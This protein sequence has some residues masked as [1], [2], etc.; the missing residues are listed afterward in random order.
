MRRLAGVWLAIIFEE[1]GGVIAN[2]GRKK[3]CRCS[4]CYN[5]EGSQRDCS[6]DGTRWDGDNRC[7]ESGMKHHLEDCLR[8]YASSGAY[9]FH[10]PGHKRVLKNL[11]AEG[12]ELYSYDI[13]E[14]DGFDNLHDPQEILAE[15][16]ALAARLYGVRKTF[17]LVGGSTLGILTAISSAVPL[18]G[19][20]L[21]ERGCH[22]SVYHA[23]H[24]RQLHI[25]YI[26]DPW[27]P[28]ADSGEKCRKP[29]KNP[30]VSVS[31]TGDTA[32]KP[33]EAGNGE[34]NGEN[35]RTYDAI[36]LTSPTYEGAV[37]PVRAWAAFARQ[38][39]AILIIDEAHGAHL[40]FHADFPSSATANGADLVVQSLH[41]TLPALTQTALLHNVSGRVEDRKIQAFLDIYETS[42]PSYLLLASV[43]A[44]LHM[45]EKARYGGERHENSQAGTE[46]GGK[47]AEGSAENG[48]AEHIMENYVRRLRGLRARLSSLKNFGLFGGVKAKA[49][50]GE[51]A[52][53]PAGTPLDPGKIVLLSRGGMDGPA[54]YQTLRE[55]YRLQPEMCGP[56]YVLCM[57]TVADTGEGFE[58]LASAME[59]LDREGME[60]KKIFAA[61][62]AL[63]G[64]EGEVQEGKME[65][66]LFGRP[67]PPVA[68]PIYEAAEAETEFVPIVETAGRISTGY[69]LL[70]PPDAPLI[71]PGEVFTEEKIQEILAWREK[72]F[73][74]VGLDPENRA[75]VAT[76]IVRK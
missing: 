39:N 15:E 46:E 27:N 54:L 3:A 19:R 71:V 44:T 58:C 13:T 49:R 4:A 35:G 67:L 36:V 18:G 5:F 32:A 34:K 59:E 65:D 33:S 50:E 68:C 9:A 11:C 8:A 12:A 28:P 30:D 16:M 57:T 17:F 6:K 45:L 76:R 61:D 56:D 51:F 63:E 47:E 53:V 2:P 73:H 23:A 41:K 66:S 72:G 42:S 75:A 74:V 21:I 43:T 7:E 60:D 64:E 62:G 37:R 22:I 40:P 24:L 14:I 48:K 26:E 70:Y 69:V 10:M 20:I 25:S 38:M 29:T 52:G 55:K 1:T 31:P